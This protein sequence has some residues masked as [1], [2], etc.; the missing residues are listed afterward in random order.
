MLPQ[1]AYF[2]PQEEV[3][4]GLRLAVENGVFC[5]LQLCE[6]CSLSFQ[7]DPSDDAAL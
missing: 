2:W 4:T 6:D 3:S 7:Q 5:N 1:P